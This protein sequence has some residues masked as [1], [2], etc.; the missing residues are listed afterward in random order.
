MKSKFL[1]IL[2]IILS[3]FIYALEY[4]FFIFLEKKYNI[5][6]EYFTLIK[7]SVFGITI[8]YFIFYKNK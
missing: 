6:S 4:L 5:K 7:H 2:W 8:F 1:Y 3:I